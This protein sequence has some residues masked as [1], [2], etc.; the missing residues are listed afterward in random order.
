MRLK[1]DPHAAWKLWLFTDAGH[2]SKTDHGCSTSGSLLV[3]SGGGPFF[4]VT[5]SI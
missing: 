4:P 2:A 3:I 1:L 5:F